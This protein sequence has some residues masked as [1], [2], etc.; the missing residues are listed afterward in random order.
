MFFSIDIFLK[1]FLRFTRLKFGT[2]KIYQIFNQLKNIKYFLSLQIY[3]TSSE[4]RPLTE[5][6]SWRLMKLLV[7]TNYRCN[8]VT[9]IA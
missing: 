6:V 9:L 8:V 3:F 4:T 5:I 1:K 2:I 7:N